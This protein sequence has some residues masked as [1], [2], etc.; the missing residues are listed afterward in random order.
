M[1]GP[2]QK[3][4]WSQNVSKII[5]KFKIHQFIRSTK[6]PVSIIYMSCCPNSPTPPLIS[7]QFNHHFWLIVSLRE[8]KGRNTNSLETQ[9][10]DKQGQKYKESARTQ[11][12][13]FNV[14]PGTLTISIVICSQLGQCPM[15][16]IKNTINLQRHHK[17]PTMHWPSQFDP[18]TN[19]VQTMST[20]TPS[21][22]IDV[23]IQ[24]YQC[25]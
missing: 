17:L 6:D 13:R 1:K 21:R 20:S 11:T 19:N 9:V 18:H 12:S 10:L 4:Q 5:K 23:F 16:T 14:T 8:N 24:C 22:L 25:H 3:L 2:L 15:S 7:C